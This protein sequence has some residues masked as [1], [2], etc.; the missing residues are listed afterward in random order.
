MIPYGRQNID[1][2]DIAA[3]VATLRSDFLTQGPA[4]E[5]FESAVAMRCNARFAVAVNSATSALWLAYRALG[6]GPGDRLWTSPNTFVATANA[7]LHLGA[8][9][10]FVDIDP[11]TYN[12]CPKRLAEKLAVAEAAGRLPKIVT[13]VHFAGQPCDLP[14]IAELAVRYGFRV[15]EDASHAIGA[16]YQGEPVG[17]CRWSDLTV[18]S[19]H[20]VKI[21]TTGEGGMVLGRDPALATRL[22]ELRSHG[23]TRDPQRMQRECEGGWY[24]EQIDLGWNFR[25]TDIQAALGTSQLNRLDAF[26]AQRQ[27]LADRYDRELAG[28]PLMRPGRD[29]AAD[30]AWHLY[31]VRLAGDGTIRRQVFNA[32]RQQGIGVNVHYIPVHIQ[33]YYQAMGFTVGAYPEAERYYQ[34]AISLPL[35]A[36]LTLEQQNQVIERLQEALS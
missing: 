31:V 2:A 18:F 5:Q 25:L 26:L 7:A 28:L 9:V 14:A 24:Y 20:P 19:F 23:V 35:F 34:Q 30:S 21:M 3:V 17:S 16:S 22:V 12:L 4:V 11:D 33:P 1:E 36:G 8:E 29:P 13:P 27:E 6:L 32:L 15:V 10:D